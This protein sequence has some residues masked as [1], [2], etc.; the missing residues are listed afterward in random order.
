MENRAEIFLEK[1]V[2]TVR[3]GV[4]NLDVRPASIEELNKQELR[5]EVPLLEEETE[6]K[7]R[8]VKQK[9]KCM[10]ELQ[11]LEIE[12]EVIKLKMRKIIDEVTVCKDDECLSLI[13]IIVCNKGKIT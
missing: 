9:R 2:E 4:Q 7:S 3:R 10:Q 6:R 5:Q 8:L 1:A 11:M 13:G 12:E